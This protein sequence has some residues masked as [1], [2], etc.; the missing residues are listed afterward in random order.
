MNFIEKRNFD[1]AKNNLFSD[2][3]MPLNKHYL[4]G[5]SKEYRIGRYESKTKDD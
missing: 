3:F 4:V 2:I 5:K 1:M